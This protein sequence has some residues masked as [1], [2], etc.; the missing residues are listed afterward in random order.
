MRSRGNRDAGFFAIESLVLLGCLLIATVGVLVAY[1]AVLSSERSAT[2]VEAVFFAQNE[3][4]S[5]LAKGQPAAAEREEE[6][7]GTTYHIAHLVEEQADRKEVVARVHWT[8]LG[9]QEQ[10]ELRRE[11]VEHG[12]KK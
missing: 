5:F 7:D 6:K 4:E 10:L 1:R 11:V 12:T 3:I 9:R 2:R 8:V